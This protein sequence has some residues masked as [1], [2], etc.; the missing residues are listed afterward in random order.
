MQRQLLAALREPLIGASRTRTD[1]P[2]R[3]GAPSAAFVATAQAWLTPSAALDP[4]ARLELYHRH[5]WYRLLDSLTD[6][7]PTV[8][9]IV[10][11]PAFA[12]LLE[13]YLTADVSH[14]CDLRHLG[15]RLADFVVRGL[16]DAPHAQHAADAARLESAWLAAFDAA[17]VPPA[18]PAQLGA[19][20]LGLQ[21][22]I[23]LLACRTAADTL[24]R[25]AIHGRARGH[26]APAAEV[27]DRFLVVHREGLQQRVERLH[28]AAHAIL[29][30][31]EAVGALERALDEG[32][33][34]LPARGGAA[35]IEAWF[36]DWARRG[37]L[38]ARA[39]LSGP[40]R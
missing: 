30:A 2:P 25:R 13:R 8:R 36:R 31:I 3:A 32:A 11:K 5:Y 33:P 24:W 12:A 9:L 22:H 1:L 34:L 39:A 16:A 20:L 6:D 14:A 40:A 18:A 27:P 17:D 15:A 38:V 4:V 29:A 21:P 35:R 10:G 28:P 7:F 26:L 37:W 23:T 19:V